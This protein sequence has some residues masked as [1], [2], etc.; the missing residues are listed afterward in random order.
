M[1]RLQSFT[2][3]KLVIDTPDGK[4]EVENLK[5]KLKSLG[6]KQNAA[7]QWVP[8]LG[9]ESMSGRISIPLPDKQAMVIALDL[10]DVT[11]DLDAGF[12]MPCTVM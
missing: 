3:P 2:A 1:A 5:L 6:F 7:K 4:V 8:V 10:N 9:I 11:V 12:V